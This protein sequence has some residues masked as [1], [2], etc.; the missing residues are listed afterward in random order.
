VHPSSAF[1][2]TD[3]EIAQ[4]A[5][6]VLEWDVL[7]PHG[8][9]RST[10]AGGWVTLEGVV[11]TWDECK[12]AE[13]AV[14]RLPGVRGV[15]DNIEL[16]P[17]TVESQTIHDEIEHALVRRAQ[18][19]AGQIGVEVHDG[20]V[21]VAGPVHSWHEHEEVLEA[22]RATAGVHRVEDRLTIEQGG[23]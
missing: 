1:E 17:S 4:A 10:T 20:S 18:R 14:R 15:V 23:A 13:Q 22:A 12:A 3:T 9:I 7:I 2:P 11:A 21:S 16:G 8:Q 5:R 19:H 6:H